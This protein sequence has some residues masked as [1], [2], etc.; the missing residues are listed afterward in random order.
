MVDIKELLP[1]IKEGVSLAGYTSFKIGGLAKYFFEAN[2]KDELINA[3]QAAEQTNLPFF[4]LA[5]GSNILFSDD[6][7]N[8][9]V[10]KIE[11][12]DFK[13]QDLEIYTEAGTKLSDIVDL[14]VE[15]GLTGLEWAAGIYGTTGGA[16]RGNAGAFHR[17][18]SIITKKVEVFDILDK[19]IKNFDNK[20][21][22][23]A[24]RESIF[25]KNKDLVILSVLFKLKK[26]KE[27]RIKKQMWQ[28]IEYRA[29]N[30]PLNKPSAGSVFKNP[31]S[32]IIG[33]GLLKDYPDLRNFSSSGIVPA[34]FLIDKAGL[35]GKRI[36]NAKI[37]EKH[38][39]FI[40]N[41]GRARAEDVISLINLV[42]EKV[43]AL[44]GIELEQ[45]VMIVK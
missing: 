10:I 45:E 13:R 28:N 31:Q 44:F 9:L 33:K 8:G 29:E 4:I 20:D 12:S 3:L 11:F 26:G 36:G 6:G 19:K 27:E 1:T 24:Y 22:E 40:I 37:S 41:L 35:R 34:G 14:A 32:K 43:G 17:S 15:S 7:F 38:C 5:G 18:M 30:Q 2:T 39:N 21:C 42:K 23:F 25:K 16:V